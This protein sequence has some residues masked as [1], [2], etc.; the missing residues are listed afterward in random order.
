MFTGSYLHNHSAYNQHNNHYKQYVLLFC[1]R[2]D[3]LVCK[4]EEMM[5]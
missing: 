5:K 2:L 4:R 1:N 3:S